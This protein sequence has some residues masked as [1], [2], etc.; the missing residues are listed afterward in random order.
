MSMNN[1]RTHRFAPISDDFSPVGRDKAPFGRDMGAATLLSRRDMRHKTTAG[2]GCATQ[3]P[4]VQQVA[5]PTEII[6]LAFGVGN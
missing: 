6:I 1:G 3:F 5:H 4:R 2:V